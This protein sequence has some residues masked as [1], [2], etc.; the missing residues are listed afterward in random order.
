MNP[1]APR[2][3]FTTIKAAK[4]AS[5]RIAASKKVLRLPEPCG[6]CLGWHLVSGLL[7]KLS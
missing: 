7:A 3:R 5:I 2:K 6:K 1:C 4:A